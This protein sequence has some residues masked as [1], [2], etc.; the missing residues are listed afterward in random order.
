M[1]P[2]LEPSHAAMGHPDSGYCATIQTR[3]GFA[4]GADTQVERKATSAS[5]NRFRFRKAKHQ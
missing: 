5:D 3:K 4:R 1:H 2:S